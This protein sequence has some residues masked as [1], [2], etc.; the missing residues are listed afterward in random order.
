MREIRY[1]ICMNFYFISLFPESFD[2]YINSSILKRASDDKKISFSFF[3]PRDFTDNRA[4]QVDDKPYGGGPGMVIQAE[5][6][7]KAIDKAV[8]RKKNVL[9]VHLSPTG[10]S[11]ITA[12]A[13]KIHKK[14]KHVVIVC[15]RYEGID[16]RVKEVFPGIEY[17]IGD[18]VLTGGELPAMVIA[19]TIARFVPGVLGK[20]ESNET[21]RT[22]SHNMYTR[23]EVLKYKKKTYGVPKVL[24]GGDH[25]KI[26]EWRRGN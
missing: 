20:S 11:F 21:E 24:L 2:S 1:D 14:Y 13:Q 18:Y 9:I 10:K 19:D 15:G 7:I 22:A 12:E 16:S 8:G 17:T 26:E 4:K 3:N 6:V 25:K 23:P 5:P